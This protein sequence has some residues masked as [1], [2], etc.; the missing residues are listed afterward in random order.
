MHHTEDMDSHTQQRS[1]GAQRRY[2]AP[3]ITCGSISNWSG[4]NWKETSASSPA[5]ST[6]DTPYDRPQQA[7]VLCKDGCGMLVYMVLSW[8]LANLTLNNTHKCILM[9]TYMQRAHTGHYVHVHPHTHLH[10]NARMCTC[11]YPHTLTYSLAAHS[12]HAM[13]WS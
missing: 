5:R 7:M 2:L 6:G 9:T 10:T 12:T 13:H 1:T 8:V 4:Y 11:T 3:V